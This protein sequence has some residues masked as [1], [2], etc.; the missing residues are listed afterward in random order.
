MTKTQG[1]FYFFY[2]Y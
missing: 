1:L 2:V